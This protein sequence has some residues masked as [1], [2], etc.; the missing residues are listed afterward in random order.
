[1]NKSQKIREYL[2]D[3]P[4][5]GPSE[6]ARELKQ[7]GVTAALVSN[8]KARGDAPVRRKK[9]RGRKRSVTRNGAPGRRR[10]AEAQPIVAAAE[11]IRLCGGVEEAKAALNTAGDVAS[12]LR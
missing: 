9:R 3:H 7:F 5:A 1:V 4:E 12:V 2:A 6:V 8:V 10:R 11:L